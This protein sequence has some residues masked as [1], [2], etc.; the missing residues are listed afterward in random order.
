[1]V[2]PIEAREIHI[3]APENPRTIRAPFPYRGDKSHLAKHIPPLVPEHHAYV[4]PFWEAAWIFLK[5]TPSKV[6][7][8]NDFKGELVNLSCA[9][10]HHYDEFVRSYEFSFVSREQFEW[11]KSRSTKHFTDIQRTVRF[12][13]IQ[14]LSFR[15]RPDYP[16]SS[17][18]PD[19]ATN[20]N[21]N[22]LKEDLEPVHSRI[23][24]TYIEN[25]DAMDYISRYDRS[26][27]LFCIDPPHWK[28]RGYKYLMDEGDFKRLRNTLLTLK[29]RFILSLND[30]PEVRDLFSEFTIE[31]VDT[32]YSVANHRSSPNSKRKRKE[33][34]IHNL[35]TP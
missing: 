8:L 13:Y 26:K 6:E 28:R 3:S 19:C 22:R 20:L 18:S 4:E 2:K 21:P 1:M 34:L 10:Q 27:T 32:F 23:K 16:S 24:P 11:E 31:T 17:S 29:G 14:K 9:V 25:L 15:G 12:F 5:K 33:L 30:C 35:Q 7:I